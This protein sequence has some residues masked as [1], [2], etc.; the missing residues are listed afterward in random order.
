MSIE[1]KETS[2]E[3]EKLSNIPVLPLRDVVV[4]PHMVIPLFVGR[5]KS[6][7][8]LEAAMEGYRVMTIDE[9]SKIGDIFLTI[10]GNKH[11]V[12]V[13]HLLQMKVRDYFC[14]VSSFLIV[15]ILSSSNLILS[16]SSFIFEF[17]S[18]S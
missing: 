8:A 15:P 2:N 17:I 13:K 10:T 5:G 14:W 18:F 16:L 3:T 11:V 7:K 12:D 4:F 6:I 1:N 9:A